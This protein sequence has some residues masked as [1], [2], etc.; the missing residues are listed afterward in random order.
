MS[1]DNMIWAYL[2][3]LGECMWGDFEPG[4]GGQCLFTDKVSFDQNVWLDVSKKLHEKQ[5]CNMI[6]IDIGEGVIFDSHPEIKAPGA[7]TK[8]QLKDEILRLRGLGFEVIPKLNFATSHD[9]W[10][11]IY[12]RMV[13]TPQYY[14]FCTDVIDEMCELFD[15]PRFFHL[16]MDE[17]CFSIQKRLP[18]CIIRHHSLFWHDM[19]F[20]FKAVEKN[21]SRP[22]IW[23]DYVWHTP[24]SQKS[25]LENMTKDILLSN[26]YYGDWTHTDTFFYDSMCAYKLLEEHGFDQI[27]TAG[28]C[29]RVVEYNTK[30]MKLT[31]E[32]TI[33]TIAPERLKGYM[34][35]SW[36]P[37]NEIMRPRLMEA[38]DIMDDGFKFYHNK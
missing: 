4:D 3:H 1:K 22:W 10:M 6:I 11:G 14:K 29:N 9:K 28:N 34:M 38:V 23:A 7:L 2:M 8:K 36:E 20:L 33:N 13:S 37:T 15:H 30:S 5:C 32:N 31:I 19:N 18:L 17:E 25:F 12:S 27:P 35:T 24:E 21:G 16:G 26:W